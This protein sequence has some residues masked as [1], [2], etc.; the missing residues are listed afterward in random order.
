MWTPDPISTLVY[1]LP[2]DYNYIPLRLYYAY[3]VA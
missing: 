3:E 1:N 2:T